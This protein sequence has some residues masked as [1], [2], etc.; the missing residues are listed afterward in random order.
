MYAEPW[1]GQ[2]PEIHMMTVKK[3]FP[4]AENGYLYSVR[5]PAQRPVT[6]YTPRI[7]PAFEGARVP[8][9]AERIL[10]YE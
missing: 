5:I 2:E 8:L 10:W 9:E 1:K 4:G 3:S 7:I 6:D